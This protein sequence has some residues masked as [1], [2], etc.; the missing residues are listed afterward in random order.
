MEDRVSDSA[1]ETELL[2]VAERAARA[3]AVELMKRWG[4]PLTVRTKSTDTDPVS[5]ADEAAE[6]AIRDI[7]GRERPQDSIL[8]EEG[9]ATG[10]GELQWI[11]DPLDGTVNY[12]YGLPHFA[13][14]I[15]CHDA[16]GGLV[17]A[18]YDPVRDVMFTATRSGE[19]RSGDE[20]LTSSKV[21]DVTRA[22]VG[23]GFG[24]D[25]GV[26]ALQGAVVARIVPLVRDVRRMGVA[27][28]DLCFAAG[29]RLDAYF[30]RGVKPWD[31]AAGQ[32][33]CERAGL[34][35][36]VLETV[37]ASD[38]FPELPKGILV[39]P[40]AIVDA[41]EALVRGADVD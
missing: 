10:D 35:V 30:E 12:L 20:L 16:A 41:L 37:P 38:G 27:A 19:P 13:V 14:S 39:A 34:A 17:G 33:I 28:L 2:E 21:T 1:L 8:G 40:P 32:L 23:T 22:L 29:G 3:A 4:G 7:L 6:Q 5:E 31:I 15:G 25:P 11:V 36:R 26:R 24:Y 9:G 18:V